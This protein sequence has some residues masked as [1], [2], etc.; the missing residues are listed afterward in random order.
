MHVAHIVLTLL[1]RLL[2]VDDPWLIQKLRIS[3]LTQDHSQNCSHDNGYHFVSVVMYIS[4]AKLKST[5]LNIS[6]DVLD[7][8]CYSLSATCTSIKA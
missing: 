7:S 2:G 5:A 6:R 3:V 1:I 4:C 8:V